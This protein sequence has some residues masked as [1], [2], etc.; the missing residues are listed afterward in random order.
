MTVSPRTVNLVLADPTLDARLAAGLEV[1]GGHRVWTGYVDTDGYGRV[2][3]LSRPVGVH[4]AVWVLEHGD[5]ADGH[6]ISPACGVR[7]CVDHLEEVPAG[8]VAPE[9]PL[10]A[11]YR[12]RTH[13]EH[14]HRFDADNTGWRAPQ[15]RGGRMR[16]YR[17]CME[18]KRQAQRRVDARRRGRRAR[19]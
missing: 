19:A 4:L 7:N 10:A 1:R 6:V 9:P 2:H 16:R 3:A 14:G 12:G 11:R 18:C 5:V 8:E 17:Y 15:L 13:C